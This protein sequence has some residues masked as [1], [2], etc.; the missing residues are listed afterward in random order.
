MKTRFILITLFIALTAAGPLAAQVQAVAERGTGPDKSPV[1]CPHPISTTIVRNQ[2]PPAPDP[3][4]FGPQASPLVAG[5]V[6]NQT[7]ADKQFGASFK[8][9]KKECCVWTQGTLIVTLKALQ[10]GPF[11]SASSGNDGVNI[12]SNGASVLAV[13]PWPNGVTTAGQTT[14]LTIQIPANVL[15]NNQFGLYVQDDTAVVSA[16][17]RLVG[18]CIR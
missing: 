1:L 14:T 10:P 7:V 6:W 9:P 5:S 12:F 13:T 4:D 16:E 18:C 3:A 15:A 8:L 11:K 2:Q 17:L